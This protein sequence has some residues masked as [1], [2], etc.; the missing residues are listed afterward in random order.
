[1]KNLF[2]AIANDEK[3]ATRCKANPILHATFHAM[4]EYV[5]EG[6]SLSD[7]PWFSMTKFAERKSKKMAKAA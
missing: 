1:M 6:K 3:F 7:L 4:R 2:D 5:S